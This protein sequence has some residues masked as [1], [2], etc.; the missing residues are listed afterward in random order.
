MGREK[1]ILRDRPGLSCYEV[2]RESDGSLLALVA[3]GTEVV[4]S[5]FPIVM[6]RFYSISSHSTKVAGIVHTEGEVRDRAYRCAVDCL[7]ELGRAY[8][9]SG[10]Q[11]DLVDATRMAREALSRP[12]TH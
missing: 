10:N 8:E 2:I 11:A 9:F 1:F 5:H 12:R 3:P 7:G 4:D 6:T